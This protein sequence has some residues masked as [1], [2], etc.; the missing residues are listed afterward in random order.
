MSNIK[1]FESNQIRTVWNETD[2]KWYFSVQDVVQL[3]TDTKDVKDYIKKMK[4]RDAE[5]NSNWGTICP[6]VEM[7]ASDGK[8]RKVQAANAQVAAIS[9][10]NGTTSA[11]ITA[12]TNG[13]IAD[14]NTAIAALNSD[15]NDF[16]SDLVLTLPEA[17]SLLTDLLKAQAQAKNPADGSQNTS[18]TNASPVPV[19]SN[20]VLASTNW[21]TLANPPWTAVI[22]FGSGN[23]TVINKFC[24]Y[25][26][27]GLSHSLMSLCFSVGFFKE[28]KPLNKDALTD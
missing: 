23:A 26:F 10:A 5:L 20:S 13:A 4:K 12:L 1:L 24:Y 2:Q 16:S 28:I 9:S 11:A 17:N 8:K 21:T 25:G 18:T 3:L 15:F 14:A 27:T 7:T 19:V 6:L 22:D